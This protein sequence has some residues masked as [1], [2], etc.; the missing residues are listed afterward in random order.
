MTV[1]SV[2]VM[3]FWFIKKYPEER[4]KLLALGNVNNSEDAADY[5][6]DILNDD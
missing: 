3:R 1:F 5:I 6:Q 2:E 4:L